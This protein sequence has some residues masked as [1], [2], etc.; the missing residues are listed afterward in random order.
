MAEEQETGA[1]TD[2]VWRLKKLCAA[3]DGQVEALSMRVEVLADDLRAAKSSNTRRSRHSSCLRCW[4]AVS[5]RWR[6]TWSVRSAS[7]RPPPTPRVAPTSASRPWMR[8]AAVCERVAGAAAGS[9]GHDVG[10]LARR[11]GCCRTDPRSPDLAVE[12]EALRELRELEPAQRARASARPRRLRAAAR[13]ASPE[14]SGAARRGRAAEEGGGEGE[15]G[16]GGEGGGEGGGGGEGD[17]EP[18]V[19]PTLVCKSSSPRWQSATRSSANLTIS[20]VISSSRARN[21]A[22]ATAPG[23]TRPVQRPV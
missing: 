18:C 5:V 15:G 4:P 7:N 1:D 19:R 20:S 6:R 12:V 10:A 17:G 2:D 23:R 11:G 13:A 21:R 3:K 9:R 22:G 16:E 8:R 14:A